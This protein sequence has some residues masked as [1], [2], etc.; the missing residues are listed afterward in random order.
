VSQYPRGTV[1]RFREYLNLNCGSGYRNGAYHQKSR[2]YGD[3]LY[4]QDRDKFFSDL[5]EA[6]AGRL[7]LGFVNAPAADPVKLGGPSL[8]ASIEDPAA[9][10]IKGR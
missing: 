7:C 1:K 2:G 9:A 6:L 10:A 5:D 3:Y 8:S 4:A